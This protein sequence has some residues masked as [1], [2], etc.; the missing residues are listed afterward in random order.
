MKTD[1]LL[2]TIVLK[3]QYEENFKEKGKADY[4]NPVF[5][6]KIIDAQSLAAEFRILTLYR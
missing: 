6:N 5:Q 3:R 2:R 1:P 4:I